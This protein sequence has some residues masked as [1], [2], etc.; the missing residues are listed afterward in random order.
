MSGQH[1]RPRGLP[2][3]ALPFSQNESQEKNPKWHP[4][5]PCPPGKEGRGACCKQAGL[6][7]RC[8]PAI[9]HPLCCAQWDVGSP[10]VPKR[11]VAPA[12]RQ[13]AGTS[14]GQGSLGARWGT[15]SS[16]RWDVARDAS[17]LPG[18]ACLSP[19]GKGHRKHG[20][21]LQ[22]AAIPSTGV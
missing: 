10:P 2:Q 1:R 19:P 12:E 20:T 7:R 18:G 17:G 21:W 8:G 11:P 14:R 5:V 22:W 6:H 9:S 13:P 15:S 4:A 3:G 16:P